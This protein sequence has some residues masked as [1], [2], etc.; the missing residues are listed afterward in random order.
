MKR[1]IQAASI[2]AGLAV[3]GV[4][5]AGGSEARAKGIIIT[6]G[7]T[8]H[9]PDPSFNYFFKVE[10]TPDTTLQTGGFFT[11]YDLLGINSH[12]L[13]SQP[14]IFWGSSLQLK[15]ITPSGVNPTDSPSLWNIT[16]KW[17]GPDKVSGATALSL[18]TFRA[19]PLDFQPTNT[20]IYVGSLD[21]KTASNQGTVKL[22]AIPEP[23]SLVLVL[24]GAGTLPL[25]LR[26]QKRRRTGTKQPDL[27]TTP[28]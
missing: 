7:G 3:L 23:S 21:G 25:L 28:G 19:G 22:N 13:T 24:A 2:L 11:V 15:G 5:L 20:V 16:W 18:G 27:V 9:N 26:C 6:S 1:R 14:N 10:L 17:L 8:Q 4:T 12:S